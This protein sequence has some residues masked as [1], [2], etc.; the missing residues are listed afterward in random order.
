MCLLFVFHSFACHVSVLCFSCLLCFVAC[1]L[2]RLLILMITL[3]SLRCSFLVAVYLF[4]RVVCVFISSACVYRFCL[5][6]HNAVIFHELCVVF[7]ISVIMLRY[8]LAGAGD[9]K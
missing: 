8:L 5:C 7:L 1:A 9:R 4:V 2:P 3:F 6:L